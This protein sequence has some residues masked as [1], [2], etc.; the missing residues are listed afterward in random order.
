MQRRSLMSKIVSSITTGCISSRA[1]DSDLS[2]GELH[3]L[4]NPQ[5]MSSRTE[6]ATFRTGADEKFRLRRELVAAAAGF[7]FQDNRRM[8]IYK[9]YPRVNPPIPV[10][11]AVDEK[12]RAFTFSH[13][14]RPFLTLRTATA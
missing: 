12:F 6:R 7:N 11:S 9:F 14:K 2:R 5:T 4:V 3:R 8:K 10:N 13:R 1:S